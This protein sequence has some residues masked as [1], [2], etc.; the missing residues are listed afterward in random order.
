[1]SGIGL[2]AVILNPAAFNVVPGTADKP[3]GTAGGVQAELALPR[4][5]EPLLPA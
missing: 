3:E 2:C 1:M 4:G 5:I